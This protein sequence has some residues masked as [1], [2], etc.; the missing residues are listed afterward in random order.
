MT[1]SKPHTVPLDKG[2]SRQA[3]RKALSHSL[4]QPPLSELNA[5]G[6]GLLLLGLL[7]IEQSAHVKEVRLCT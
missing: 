5:V 1:D 6:K 7:T 4:C 2:K 3:L